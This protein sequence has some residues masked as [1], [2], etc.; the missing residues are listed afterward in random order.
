MHNEKNEEKGNNSSY[1]FN[2]PSEDR[3]KSNRAVNR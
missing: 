2:E 3:Y 1:D